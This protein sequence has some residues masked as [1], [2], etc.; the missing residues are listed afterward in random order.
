MIFYTSR[1]S[2]SASRFDFNLGFMKLLIILC[3]FLEKLTLCKLG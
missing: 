1:Q 2:D 3:Y